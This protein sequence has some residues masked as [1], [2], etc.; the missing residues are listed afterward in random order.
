MV[1]LQRRLPLPSYFDLKYC[2]KARGTSVT[3]RGF[4]PVRLMTACYAGG[5][6]R[7]AS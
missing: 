5:E 2:R 3:V 1:K 4:F 7:I 6:L